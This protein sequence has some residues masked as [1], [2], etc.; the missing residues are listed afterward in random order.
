MAHFSYDLRAKTDKQPRCFV[1]TKISAFPS[2]GLSVTFSHNTT[3]IELVSSE[4]MQSILYIVVAINHHVLF[5]GLINTMYLHF[6]I[7]CLL[8]VCLVRAACTAVEQFPIDSCFVF[9]LEGSLW[10]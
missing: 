10:W 9:K 4:A 1:D 2:C 5:S 6:K 3:Y 8:D 7:Y